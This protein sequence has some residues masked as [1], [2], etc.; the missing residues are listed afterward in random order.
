M[1]TEEEYLANFGIAGE[2]A[3]QLEVVAG[4]ATGVL[5]SE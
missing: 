1:Q 4:V 2:M 5:Q 3:R